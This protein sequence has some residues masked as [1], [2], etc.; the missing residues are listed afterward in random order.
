MPDPIMRRPGDVAPIRNPVGG[1]IVF[2]VRGDETNGSLTALET[3]AGPGEG[4]P[5]HTRT[6]TRTS[7]SSCSRAPSGFG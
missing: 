1:D 7:A 3:I 4:P 2:A 6:R 5:F